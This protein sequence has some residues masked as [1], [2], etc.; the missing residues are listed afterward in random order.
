MINATAARV[1]V[2][3]S[4]EVLDRFLVKLEPKIIAAATE[5]RTTLTVEFDHD[6][7]P[8][9]EP[10]APAPL[11]VCRAAD[12]LRA[13]GFTVYIGDHKYETRGSDEMR[14]AFNLQVKW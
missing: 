9:V 11:F 2:A 1:L 8:H 10:S 7:V 13:L 14:K 6:I 3:A 4:A 5:G 12:K